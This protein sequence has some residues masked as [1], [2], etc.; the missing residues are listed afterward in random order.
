[1]DVAVH[2]HHESDDWQHCFDVQAAASGHICSC[3]GTHGGFGMKESKIAEFLKAPAGER[4]NFEIMS[5]EPPKLIVTDKMKSIDPEM[6]KNMERFNS[7][8]A[9]WWRKVEIGIAG[10]PERRQK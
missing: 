6:A 2:G 3:R 4:S 7:E 9:E 8:L 1:E 10:A 5:R